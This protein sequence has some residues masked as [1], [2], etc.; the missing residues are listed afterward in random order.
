M[1][2]LANAIRM[3]RTRLD[4]TMVDFAERIGCK[5]STISRYESGKLI[6]GRS[7]LMLLLQLAKG[8]ERPPILDQLGVTPATMEGWKDR[9]L[10]IA[11]Q[12]FDQYLEGAGKEMAVDVRENPKVQFARAARQIVLSNAAVTPALV[13]I[14]KHW[15]KHA[16]K[17]DLQE[18]FEHVAAY[19]DVELSVL[20]SRRRKRRTS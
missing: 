13:R 1:I 11:L 15:L 14:V 5:Q 10:M 12:T 16:G 6:P 18:Y 9:D 7:V 8:S 17:P 3:I 2:G 19:L 20:G 4:L